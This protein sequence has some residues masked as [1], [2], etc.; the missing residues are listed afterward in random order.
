MGQAQTMVSFTQT[1]MPSNTPE[2]TKTARPPIVMKLFDD[3][4]N[5]WF[6]FGPYWKRYSSAAAPGA[7]SG[8]AVTS[9]PG[10]GRNI[11]AALTVTGLAGGICW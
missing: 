4:N 8:L 7:S 5:D 3:F 9:G 2:P 6:A 1:A 10:T 11:C